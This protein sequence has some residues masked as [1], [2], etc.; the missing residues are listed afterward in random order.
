VK[1]WKGGAQGG[2]NLK[3]TYSVGLWAN[4]GGD[5]RCKGERVGNR[6]NTD[7]DRMRVCSTHYSD[8]ESWRVVAS[9]DSTKKEKEG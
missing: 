7:K 6:E 8:G 5:S 1:V 3:G 2:L 9:N 4:K